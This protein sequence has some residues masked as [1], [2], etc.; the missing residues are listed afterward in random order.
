VVL[1]PVQR[2]FLES[3]IRSMSSFHQSVL[4]R[5]GT[6]VE[7]GRGERA[8][9]A[10]MQ[11]HDALRCGSS[12]LWRVGASEPGWTARAP[13]GWTRV[14]LSGCRRGSEELESLRDRS[15]RA[16]IWREPDRRRGVWFSRWGRRRACCWWCYTW[17]WTECP[18]SAA[19]GFRDG[20]RDSWQPEEKQCFRPRRPPTS[21]GPKLAAYAASW[22]PTAFGFRSGL[23]GIGSRALP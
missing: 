6:V 19:G 16:W 11:H 22:E 21:N 1:T 17:R 12:A 5:V 13:V 10:L 18:A 2:L 8:W 20:L 23:V 3:W 4:L 9:E 15:S 7:P 14:D